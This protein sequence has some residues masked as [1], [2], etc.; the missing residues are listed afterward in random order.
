MIMVMVHNIITKHK[1][2]VMKIIF[3]NDDKNII[4]TNIRIL[5]NY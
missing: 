3:K 2:V 4:S 1:T 5:E